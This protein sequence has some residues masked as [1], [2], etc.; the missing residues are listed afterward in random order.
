M[1]RIIIFVAV[2]LLPVLPAT[3]QQA[4][5]IFVGYTPAG[6]AEFKARS[7]DV[8]P[9]YTAEAT[10]LTGFQFEISTVDDSFLMLGDFGYVKGQVTSV[11]YDSVPS[12]YTPMNYLCLHFG[13]MYGWV[14]NSGHRLQ[15][16]IM[17]GP[18]LSWIKCGDS[19][20]DIRGLLFD[21]TVKVRSNFYITRRIG[22]YAG[23]GGNAGI[24]IRETRFGYTLEAGLIY[25]FDD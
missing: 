15:L 22:I 2:L 16:P 1:R 24:G 5:S 21:L 18:G 8:G 7:I 23:I 4:S 11:V 25:G 6:F 12:N 19:N 3:A 10:P 17:A 13:T 20:G 14:F 9:L